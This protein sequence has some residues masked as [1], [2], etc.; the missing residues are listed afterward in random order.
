MKKLL[1]VVD[2]QNDFIT[3]PLGTKEACDIVPK[4]ANFIEDFDGK[5]VY[6]KDTH[7]KDYLKTQEGERLPVEHCI[8][9]TSGN[10]V[11]SKLVAKQF[12]RKNEDRE[13]EEI[14]VFNKNTF[15]S[16][17]LGEFLKDMSANGLKEVHFV[18]VCTGI[19]VIS[20]AVIAKTFCPEVRIV[21][22]KD[23]CACVTPESHERALKSM[24]TLQMDIV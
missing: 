22:H 4:V 18:G 9:G 8:E 2:M 13:D 15:G 3:G 12:W 21:I 19:C 16:I 20:N 11:V 23:L 6:T 10:D 14:K 24:E 5:V 1:V 7:G 17:E